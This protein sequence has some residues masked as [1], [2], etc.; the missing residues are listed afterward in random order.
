MG[1]FKIPRKFQANGGI[2]SIFLVFSAYSIVNIDYFI[3]EIKID[4]V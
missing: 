2:L 1:I 4:I 3:C